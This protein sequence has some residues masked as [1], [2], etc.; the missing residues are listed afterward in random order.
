MLRLGLGNVLHQGRT[1]F[2]RFA[3]VL[4]LHAQGQAPAFGVFVVTHAVFHQFS[5]VTHA[6]LAAHRGVRQQ[7]L[8]GRAL[9]IDQVSHAAVRLTDQVGLLHIASGTQG[10][11]DPGA[12]RRVE[13]G[14]VEGPVQA[15]G[16]FERLTDFRQFLRAP[17]GN[18][19]VVG[20]IG[21]RDLDQVDGTLAPVAFRLDPGAWTLVVVVVQVFVVA[22][23]A[24]TLQQA[25][26]ARVFHAEIA[27]RQ[28]FRVVQRAPDPLAVAGMNRQ[29]TGVMQLATVV[30][31]LGR[32]VRAEQEHAGQRG[33]AQLADLVAQE[34]LGFDID[35]RV[36]TRAQDQ[37][38]SAGRAWRIQQGK[39]HQVLV[40]R[41][42][43]LDPELGEAR[44]FFAGR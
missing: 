23:V 9:E 30:E 35:N 11:L 42:W 3:C 19:V 8:Q 4:D 37:A 14:V 43:T 26:T 10:L 7:S 13:R 24:A 41:F 36:G 38:I 21:G 25:E 44:E 28:V 6:H 29:A 1:H 16:H 40:T 17:E 12:V 33:N 2:G 22:E 5:V 15:V 34:H 18:D 32:L 27:H 39:D 20:F 31:H